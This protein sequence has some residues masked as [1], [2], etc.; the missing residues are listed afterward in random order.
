MHYVIGDIHCQIDALKRLL[1]KLNLQPEDKVYFVG[2]WFDRAYTRRDVLETCEW[3]IENLTGNSRFLS[4]CG[5]HDMDM[6]ETI[7]YYL[8]ES[9]L[10]GDSE[11]Q[12]LFSILEDHALEASIRECYPAIK[13]MIESFPLYYEFQINGVAHLVTHSWLVDQSERPIGLEGFDKSNLNKQ[14]SIWDRRASLMEWDDANDM[15]IMIHGHTPTLGRGNLTQKVISPLAKIKHFSSK[16]IN[17]DCCAFYSPLRGGNL[18]AYCCE[19]GTEFYAYDDDVFYTLADQLVEACISHGK[20]ISKEEY[21][22]AVL[23]YNQYAVA[24]SK[25]DAHSLRFQNAE[26]ENAFLHMKKSYAD[27][28]LEESYS[29]IN[30]KMRY[31]KDILHREVPGFWVNCRKEL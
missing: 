17:V 1:D 9:E 5:N 11:E 12:R 14:W 8:E 4:V 21:L 26:A 30:R 31:V 24:L 15:P 28:S 25:E 29:E 22:F 27:Y 7:D 20:R 3:M 2:D 13:A 19:D 10:S 23:F 16:N 18:A 6:L